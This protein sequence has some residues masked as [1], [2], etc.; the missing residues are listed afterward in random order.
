MGWC[1]Q[2][3]RWGVSHGCFHSLDEGESLPPEISENSSATR[4][5]WEKQRT[6]AGT[7]M[8]AAED[9]TK[10]AAMPRTWGLVEAAREA[11]MAARS[12]ARR[13]EFL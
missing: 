10:L 13:M 3:I 4:R 7:T 8:R 9:D 1:S 6:E 5:V 2:K 12:A 11:E